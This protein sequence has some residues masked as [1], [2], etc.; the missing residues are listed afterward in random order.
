[1]F[2]SSF[3]VEHRLQSMELGC[4]N[5][6]ECCIAVVETWHNQSSWQKDDSD[7]A[8]IVLLGRLFQIVVISVSIC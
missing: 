8:E 7:F 3:D 5:C 2:Q 1:M 4:K 6:C